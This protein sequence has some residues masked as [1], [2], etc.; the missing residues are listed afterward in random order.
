M[1]GLEKPIR[2][3]QRADLVQGG[4]GGLLGE[5]QQ[6]NALGR[7]ARA[8]GRQGLGLYAALVGATQ[9]LALG[10]GGQHHQ[11]APWLTAGQAHGLVQG[12]LV[13]Q[14]QL[15]LQAEGDAETGCRGSVLSRGGSGR[16]RDGGAWDQ[17]FLHLPE[18]ASTLNV[19]SH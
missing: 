2:A 18:P 10:P 14:T 15:P 5:G 7:Q 3:Q 11:T 12:G 17:H 1:L 16:P 9:A 6:G 8:Q 19:S 4:G 13:I